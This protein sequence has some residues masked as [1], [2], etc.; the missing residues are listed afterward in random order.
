MRL[1]RF[2]LTVVLTGAAFLE[3]QPAPTANPDPA[4]YIGLWGTTRAFG[5]AIRGG[6][7]ITSREGAR[8][9]SIA[10]TSAPVREEGRRLTFEL[11]GKLGAFKGRREAGGRIR[12]FW[13]QPAGIVT[14]VA[15][16]TP[17]ELVPAGPGECTARRGLLRRRADA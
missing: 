1:P 17:V 9:A 6:L 16:A 13:I 11:A 5:P 3:A 14:G 2:L 10:G 7:T 8:I 15:W 4:R 12:G